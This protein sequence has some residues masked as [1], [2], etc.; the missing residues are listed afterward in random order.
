LPNYKDGYNH[1]NS[2]HSEGSAERC[3]GPYKYY[4]AI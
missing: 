2:S 1:S 4:K 3:I